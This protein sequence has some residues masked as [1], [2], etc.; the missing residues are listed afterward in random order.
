MMDN[1]YTFSKEERLSRK[2]DIDTLF[3]DG[4]SFIAYPLRVIFLLA[5]QSEGSVPVSILTSVSKKRFKRAVKR[6]LIKRQVRE[7]YRIQKQ[8]LCNCVQEKG[9]SLKVAFIYIDKEIY[10]QKDIEKAMAKALRVLKEKME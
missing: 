5:E 6:N 8:D 4:K 10:L 9:K 7:A 3:A 2:R 1:R